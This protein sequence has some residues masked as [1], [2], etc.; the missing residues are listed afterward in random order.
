[1]LQSR[2]VSP[3]QQVIASARLE[4]GLQAFDQLV[5]LVAHRGMG[6]FEDG[7]CSR[8]ARSVVRSRANFRA[9]RVRSMSWS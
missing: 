7:L 1:M 9:R 8:G 4:V 5:V 2:F 6:I 3:E